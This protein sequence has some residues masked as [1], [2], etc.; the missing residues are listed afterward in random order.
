MWWLLQ[1]SMCYELTWD[2]KDFF[3]YLLPLASTL[4]GT[5]WF[6]KTSTPESSGPVSG[7]LHSGRLVEVQGHI[8]SR[9]DSKHDW[10]SHVFLTEKGS[11]IF[12]LLM[13]HIKPS[14]VTHLWETSQ[15]NIINTPTRPGPFWHW[16][17]I[18]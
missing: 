6:L 16:S 7:F 14:W 5:I 17:D 18:D 13:L 12:G 11:N 15:Q 1:N 8:F 10:E 9:V 4:R 2:D 3:F